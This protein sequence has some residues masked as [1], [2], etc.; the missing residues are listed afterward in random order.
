VI[1]IEDH[2]IALDQAIGL[3]R[4]RSRGDPAFAALEHEVLRRVLHEP[5]A[6]G[7]TKPA[8]A[9]NAGT[10]PSAPAAQAANEPLDVWRYG[11]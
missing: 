5:P 9:P 8:V 4:P 1:L 10:A 7:D 11:G 3:P 2:T 6:A